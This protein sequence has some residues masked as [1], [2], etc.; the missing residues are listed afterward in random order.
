[1]TGTTGITGPTGSTGLFGPTGPT[2][3]T[4]GNRSNRRYGFY[5]T[6]G[7]NGVNWVNWWHGCHGS[8]RSNGSYGSH[9]NNGLT[10]PT[11]ATGATGATG[12]TGATGFTGPT[13]ATGN[14]GGTGFTGP[15][16]ATGNTGGTG[17]T[18]P[19]GATGSTGVTGPTGGTGIIGPT[20]ETG[21]TGAS[22][23]T[24]PTGST[25]QTGATGFTGPTGASGFTGPTGTTGTTGA[26][27]FTGPTGATGSTGQTGA[28]GMTGPTGST[29]ATGMTGSTGSTGVT[30]PTGSTGAT[31]M[32]G[33]TGANGPT[34]STG[35][36]GGTGVTGPTGASGYT[37]PTGA[38][39]MTGATG[40]TGDNG[41]TGATGMTGATGSQGAS[42]PTGVMGVTGATG[43]TGIT[44]PTGFTGTTGATGVT[45]PTGM[46]GATGLMGA[47]GEPIMTQLDNLLFPY[48]VVNRSIAL[49]STTFSPSD[50]PSTTST[51]SALI[52]LNGDNGNASFS[53]KITLRGGDSVIETQNMS[54][55]TIGSSTTGAIQLSPKGLAGLYIDSF[56]KVGIGT[57]SPAE[58]FHVAGSTAL[59]GLGEGGTPTAFT[60]RGAA[61]SGT[62]TV[63]ANMTFDASNGTGTGGSGAF[64][65]RTAP[66]FTSATVSVG[67]N[68]SKTGSAVST[69]NWSHTVNTGNDRLLVVGVSVRAFNTVSSITYGSQS[70][71]QYGS[72]QYAAGNEPRTEL[73]Y[74]VAPDVGTNTITVNLSGAD[75]ME[76]GA[77]NFYS[78]NQSVPL[79]TY[80]TNTGAA[81]P[82]SV[83][84]VGA[85]GD[86][87]IDTIATQ[88]TITV[89]ASQTQKWNI[90]SDG[91]WRG[92]GS[93]KTGSAS[94]V[95]QWTTTGTNHWAIGG[96]AVKSVGSAGIDTLVQRLIIDQN[97]NIGIGTGSPLSMLD[98]SGAA[99]GKA[100]VSF[101]ETGNQDIFTA[102]S[103]GITRFRISNDGNLLPGAD[104]TYSIGASPSARFKDVFV[105]P[106]SLHIQ[107]KTTDSGYSGLGSNLDYAL[108]IDT[109]GSFQ[110]GLN[111][112]TSTPN[113]LMTMTQGG[114]LGLGGDATLAT[115]GTNQNLMINPNGTGDVLFHTTAY[116]FTS[117]GDL[118]AQRLLDVANNSYLLDPANS[119]VSLT[120]AGSA[121]IGTIAPTGMLEVTGQ[122][123]GKALALL[124][125]TG[126][127]ALLTASASGVTKFTI[128]NDGSFTI[129]GQASNPTQ[130]NGGVVVP[131][132]VYYNNTTTTNNGTT[133][134]LFLYG[135]DSA[136]HRIALDMTAYS[137]SSANI[138]NS[139][140]IQIAHNQNTNDLS[141]TGWFMDSVSGLWK[142]IS[143]LFAHTIKNSLDNEFNASFTQKNKVT[144]VSLQYQ[145]DSL[146][147]GADGA[148]VF[149]TNPFNPNT[150]NL[151]NNC[152]TDGGDMVNYS[153]TGLTDTTATLESSPGTGCIE[154]GDEVLLINLRGKSSAY[155][156]TG[157][158]ETFRVASVTTNTVTFTTTKTK[159]Y[160]DTNP[161]TSESG[162]GTGT[163]DQAV[164]LQRVPNYT[165]VTVNTG[166]NVAPS[167]WTVPSGSNDSGAGGNG[168]GG[169]IFFR[170]TGAVSV[171][172]TG[173]INANASGYTGGAAGSAYYGGVG[174]EAF[175]GVNAGGHGVS[176]V[177]TGGTAGICGGGGGGGANT[178]S[179]Y[180][181]TAG[182]ASLGGAGGGGGGAYDGSY[183]SYGGGGAGGGYGAY[184][185]GGY[186]GNNGANGGT[187]SSGNGGA[188]TDASAIDRGGGGGG[189]GTY[190]DVNLTS[191]YLGSGGAGGGGGLSQPGGAGGSGGGIVYIAAGSVTVSSSGGVQ[192]NGGGG[193]TAL[194]NW[195]GGGGGGGA[196][197]SV[198]IVGNT[199]NLSTT[200]TASAG[201][202]GASGAYSGGSGGVGRIAVGST[203]TV[204][205]TTTP[206]YTAIPFNYSPYAVYFSQP[207]HTP[208]ATAYNN[209]SWTETLPS[210]TEIEVQTRSGA[211]ADPTDGTWEAWKPEVATTNY[212]TL[213]DANTH[214]NWTGTNL[215]V[216]EGDVARNVD[217]F[218][219]EDENNSGNLIKTTATSASGYAERTISSANISS[220]TYITTWVRSAASGSVVTLGFGNS[221]ATENTK[222]FIIDQANVW[223]KIYWDISPTTRNAVTKLRL[224]SLTNGNVIWFDDWK[225]EVYPTTPGGSTIS[226]TPNTYLQYRFILSTNNSANSPSFSQVKIN[227][228][229]N[230]VTS[231][232]DADSIIDP[233]AAI[234]N[235]T[236]RPTDPTTLDYALYST[237][238]GADGAAVFSTNPFNPNTTNL[239][240]NCTTDGGD[241]VNYSVTGLTDTTATLESSPGT[242]CIEAGDEVLLINLRG[243]SSAYGNTGNWETFR[244]A[245]VTTNTVTFTTT[246]T[247]C[248]GD[249]N[250][251]TSESGIG[252]GT[253]DQ[254]VMLQRVPNYTTVTV[255]T[256]VNVAPSAW[257]VPSGSNDSGAGG[258]G[259]GGVIFFR[260]TG[261][262]SVNGTGTI[263]A[264]ASGY[265]GGAAGSAY[266]GGVGGEAFCGVNAGGHGV[267]YVNTGG[268]AG[269]CGGGGGGGANTG[270]LY[271]A[272]AG[273]A[274]LGGAGGGGG[275]AYDGSYGSYGG[276]GAG[277]G[278]GAYGSG[279]Y[280]GNNGANGGTNSSGNGGA[281]TDASAIDRGGGGGGGG[282][283]GDVNLT[284]LY[285]GS[286]GAGGGGGLSQPGGAGGSGGG[287]VYIAAGSVTVSSSGGVQANGG[288]GGT[289][290]VN[291]YGGGGGG[292]AGGSVKIVGNTLNLS[293]TVT[294][295]AGGG[296]A[297]GAYSGGS[298]GVGRIAAYSPNTIVGTSTPNYTADT[299]TGNYNNHKVYISKE[300][301]TTGATA[302][303][304]IGWTENLPSGTEI[305]LQTRSG[306]TPISTDGTWEAWTPTTASTTI[307]DANTNGNWAGTNATV[308]D[309]V[310]A[311][312]ADYYEDEDQVAATNTVTKF[313]TTTSGGYAERTLGSPIDI[314]SRKYVELW[315]RSDVAGSVITLGLG[316]GTANIT[317]AVTINTANIWQKVYWDISSACTPTTNCDA[318]TKFRITSSVSGNVVYFDA[319]NAQSYLTTATGDTITSTANNY[320]QYRAILT[321]TSASL[322]PTFSEVRINYTNASGAQVLNDKLSNQN[323]PDAYNQAAHLNITTVNLD[324]S[325]SI[326]LTKT[327]TG[328]T[329]NNQIDVGTGLDGDVAVSSNTNINVTNL[330][331]NRACV[332]GGDA[333]NYSV[334]ALTSRSATI[335]KSPSTGCL[336]A[337]DE[338]LLI[339]LAGGTSAFGNVGN[340]ETLR[341]ESI[342]LNVINFTT[343]K[344]KYYGNGKNSDDTN[345]GTGAGSQRVMLQRVPNYRNLVVDSGI[346]YYPSAWDGTKGGVIFFRANSAVSV[347]V[348]GTI[349]A[350]I[351]G[352]VGG[353]GGG[354]YAGGI[355]GESFCSTNAGGSG[356]SY[357]AAGSAGTCGGGGGGGSNTGTTQAG[358]AGSAGLGGAGGG[359]GGGYDGSAGS[360]GAGGAGGGYGSGGAGGG[361]N[362][363]GI[364]NNGGTNSSGNGVSGYDPGNDRGGNG[365]GGG[366]YGDPNLSTLIF[367][368]GGAGGGGGLNYA[369]GAGG[370]GGGIVYIAANSITVSGAVQSNGGS[371]AV[372]GTGGW[373]GGGGGGGAGGSI[374]LLGNSVNLGHSL[375][376]TTGGAA[377][378]NTLPGGAGGT[379]RIAVN[380]GS[381]ISGSS[382]PMYSV[383][384][385]P[386]SN[387]SV[388]VSD[389]IATPNAV[390]YRKISWLADQT[391]YGIVQVQT[392]SGASNNA[393][394]GTWEQWKTATSSGVMLDNGDDATKWVPSDGTVTSSQ[395]GVIRHV[396]E[397]EDEDE[398]TTTNMTKLSFTNNVSAYAENRI[399]STDLSNFDFLTTWVYA[400]TSGTTVKLGFGENTSTEHEYQLNITAVNTW[401]KVYLDISHI[402]ISERDAVRNLR[403]TS[404]AQNNTIYVDSTRGERFLNTSTGSMI[405]ST[406]NNYLQY[407]VIL[408]SSNLGYRPTLYNIQAEWSDG[409]KIQQTDSNT[410]RLY[411]YTG[412]TQ[413]L[414]LEAIVFG[415]DLAEYYTVDDLNIG[416][417][418]L[419][420]TTGQLDEYSVPILRKTNQDNDQELLGVISTKAGQTLGLEGENRRLLALAGRVPVKIDPL[421][422][423]VK[424]GDS[425]TSSLVPGVA[426]K[427][428][429]GEVVIG[430]ALEPWS[431]TSGK[432]TIL[433]LVSNA[434]QLPG[435]TMGDMISGMSLSI[436]SASG[437]YVLKNAAGELVNRSVAL[438]DMIVATMKVGAATIYNATIDTLTINKTLVSPLAEIGEL[439]TDII[440]PLSATSS[441]IAVRLNEHQTYSIT[442]NEGSPSATF[443]SLGNVTFR[444]QVTSDTIQVQRDATISGNLTANQLTTNEAT[445]AGS[446]YADR[447]VTRF[448]DLSNQLFKYRS[449]AL[450]IVCSQYTIHDTR[451]S[452]RILSFCSL[453]I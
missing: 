168:E 160:G 329:M 331:T 334:T 120:T 104:N 84:V 324:S 436:S 19:T 148:A 165:T 39:G 151:T 285:L 424:A 41:P 90:T 259:E 136:W 368:S 399:S 131:G 390:D 108:G 358:G 287:I 36:T 94:V 177:N 203:S 387:Y 296:G 268:T 115:L 442:N 270:S 403:V 332:D 250:P 121:G 290:L 244:V 445:I 351:L 193:G 81:S 391:P 72:V 421:S 170:A 371:G 365:G 207:V 411:N 372:G 197:G 223:Q 106:A 320:I 417:G 87:I 64:I 379:G 439:H 314:S 18:G 377:G 237:G 294:A 126:N 340:Y 286:G 122:I 310:I 8:D 284:S 343:S 43:T 347:N 191:L 247:K 95:M 288:G 226:S 416:P 257:T 96:V 309:G 415:A 360:Y 99:V 56:G 378:S 429:S 301:A 85:T 114:T 414:R 196:G 57:T 27:G 12:T 289:A 97:G 453:S 413:Q 176:Y 263:N 154:A 14:T 373:N 82:A 206:G 101:N 4:R 110:L 109:S 113:A 17:F 11:G 92:G 215:T 440:S 69:M 418:D 79:G 59:F 370:S 222:T 155:G 61:A 40:F 174:G 280:G 167:A 224:T 86:M 235:Q 410:V 37:G 132:T 389:E 70:L 180:A 78:V 274:S 407:R 430:K 338:I 404:M 194:V 367:G 451:Y 313:T 317:Q 60:L 402:P 137:S 143:D 398:Y 107:A 233:R 342:A 395:S 127:Q 123:T 219:D 449:I 336:S 118:I 322:T 308:A 58:V 146:G 142:K 204:T 273:T 448:G 227:L 306:N 272:T 386:T 147:T 192:A 376:T 339:N 211:S 2:G 400:T 382:S 241:M 431:S 392:R 214:T 51:A 117:A 32:T 311:R 271:A 98:V 25:G 210:S 441:G 133:G 130:E 330:I 323:N 450:F 213:D 355:G 1:M 16:G 212:L 179:L 266:Y 190:G 28:T 406:P 48:P 7:V 426:K 318:V 200:V 156:N 181:A 195:Y 67:N 218:E 307:D 345:I 346:N 256:G 352:Y 141:L 74:L 152:T 208:N 88:Q 375:V 38:T 53:G 299:S 321:T 135:Q 316:E 326:G 77:V 149:S 217:N 293:T 359:G 303:S 71:T 292:G 312:N 267:S 33:S 66:G 279:G 184:G 116:K 374:K 341:V 412:S 248:Y 20:G 443:D 433:I 22:G 277:G 240:N 46:T 238:T 260:A 100:L 21:A 335:T 209:I 385:V 397:Y 265:T 111:G 125:E 30:G 302:F 249:T 134:E 432:P 353:A 282:T 253:G 269:I 73:W 369:G 262:V 6:N 171:N 281:A 246:K 166:V 362:G 380:Y 63:G 139:E 42:G 357:V 236:S 50:N 427:A 186:G 319:I 35:S 337:G 304:T 409:Y 258:N 428:V 444:G 251:C 68:S 264:N 216:A 297:S 91:T 150:T 232:M 162:I 153:V 393:T 419:V 159:C 140:Y 189:G 138:A 13:G 354:A 47:N 158:W 164:M 381:A 205:G 129:A 283:Y 225:A 295:S 80:A 361:S 242:G 452:I 75:F 405:A 396:T 254:A 408:A 305:E 199:L 49:G 173:T 124:N 183:G 291:W 172:G 29:G 169:V 198:K 128:N 24:G 187:N 105:G 384:Q 182:T 276:G 394:D 112:T 243:K 157:N 327:Q 119:N 275:G 333:V 102:S 315:L 62:N 234:K 10:G 298:G 328:I 221:A 231:T 230:G 83:T 161:C 45:G 364:V 435:F 349:N 245:S 145:N 54:Q 388:F 252:T 363:L 434:H 446:L 348:T 3:S 34:G 325:K 89:D 44:G 423:D 420:A 65:F 401:Q 31:G 163:G 15:T 255:N 366:T 229:E 76:A 52:F 178:G 55:L 356:G 278:Y 9:G 344:T 438:S 144:S 188:A 103:A 23:F 383:A 437:S 201:G 350:N 220:Y 239:T 93:T 228:T 26:S 175:C 422:E 447:I 202:G 185:S 425:L 300:L 261:A 5:R